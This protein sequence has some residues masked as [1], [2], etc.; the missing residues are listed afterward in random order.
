MRL[1]S[2]VARGTSD[3]PTGSLHTIIASRGKT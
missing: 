1:P 3:Q 2:D